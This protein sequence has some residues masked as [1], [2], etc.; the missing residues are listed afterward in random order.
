MDTIGMKRGVD[1]NRTKF[2]AKKKKKKKN[3]K[4]ND[5]NNNCYEL[6][7]SNTKT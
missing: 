6:T 5:T 7:W 4:Q 1:I 3:Y 2:A